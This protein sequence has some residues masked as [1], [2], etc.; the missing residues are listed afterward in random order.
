M[1]CKNTRPD[2]II[3]NFHRHNSSVFHMGWFKFIRGGA[4]HLDYTTNALES[5]EIRTT[6]TLPIDVDREVRRNLVSVSSVNQE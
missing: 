5:G 6:C 3:G 4:V 2:E 1:D